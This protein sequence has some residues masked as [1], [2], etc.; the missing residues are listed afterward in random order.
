[1]RFRVLSVVIWSAPAPGGAAVTAC[2]LAVLAIGSSRK[3]NFSACLA[4]NPFPDHVNRCY[5]PLAALGTA[6]RPFI[7]CICSLGC[8]KIVAKFCGCLRFPDILAAS[9][10]LFRYGFHVC[11]AWQGTTEKTP[12]TGREPSPDWI[13]IAGN[14]YTIP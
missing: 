9:L 5:L 3:P 10:S 4:W 2:V 8:Y 12:A 11:R 7:C 6:A 14:I 13:R 1:M